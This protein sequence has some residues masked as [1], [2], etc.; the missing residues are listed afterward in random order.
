M[1]YA[2][3]VLGIVMVLLGLLFT[4]QGLGYIGGSAMTGST[5][6]ALAG[7]VIALAGAFLAYTGVKGQRRAS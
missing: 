2:R 4:G 1:A 3:A 6:W 7:P 5:F